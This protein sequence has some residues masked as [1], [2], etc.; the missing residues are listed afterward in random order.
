[1]SSGRQECVES[2]SFP[3]KFAWKVSPAPN[4][5][6][7]TTCNLQPAYVLKNARSLSASVVWVINAWR[8]ALKA[9]LLWNLLSNFNAAKLASIPTS[10]NQKTV[11]LCPIA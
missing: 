5:W 2:A 4:A 6:M 8:R 3:A 7:V 10:S 9:S 11:L 1:M